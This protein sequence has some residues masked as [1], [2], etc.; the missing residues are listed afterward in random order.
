MQI[1]FGCVRNSPNDVRF[2]QN[3]WLGKDGRAKWPPPFVGC[4]SVGHV[5]WP[6]DGFTLI[7]FHSEFFTMQSLCA[8][9][10]SE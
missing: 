2:S 1:T 9:P 6:L 5:E 3:V 10:A 4:S 7:S 8:F